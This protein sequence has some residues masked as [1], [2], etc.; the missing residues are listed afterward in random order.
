MCLGLPWGG[1][2]GGGLGGWGQGEG[3]RLYKKD[4]SESYV[5]SSGGEALIPSARWPLRFSWGIFFWQILGGRR[6][7][8]A[9]A[10]EV[11][12]GLAPGRP[13]H[14]RE[15]PGPGKIRTPGSGSRDP[16]IPAASGSLGSGSGLPGPDPG[17][18]IPGSGSRDPDPGI[19]NP[20]SGFLDQKIQS[21]TR[22]FRSRCR[23]TY[24]EWDAVDGASTA[25][26]ACYVAR[27][28][29]RKTLVKLWIF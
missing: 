3:L 5:K 26:Y 4:K 21:L 24:Q 9:L 7:F 22:V 16:G 14:G 6:P 17:F 15:A 2:W 20:G 8:R 28:R 25:S 1:F 11:L 10:V 13:A 19:W 23:A 29:H 27:H 12:M 18:W